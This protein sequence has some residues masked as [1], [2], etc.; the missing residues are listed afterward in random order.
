ME[1]TSRDSFSRL[2]E[3]VHKIEV[4]EHVEIGFTLAGFGSRFIAYLV[5]LL[6]MFVVVSVLFTAMV[7]A[8]IIYQKS[9]LETFFK[10]PDPSAQSLAAAFIVS[11][12]G[13]ALFIVSWFYFVIFEMLWDGASP[14][15][16]LMSIRVMRDEGSKVAFTTS[17]LRNLLR[18]ADWLP[19][20]YLAGIVVMFANKKWK[21]LGDIVAGTVVVKEEKAGWTP[22]LSIPPPAAAPAL[23]PG[24]G[25]S[26]IFTDQVLERLGEP[27]YNLCLGYLKR[28]AT[29][30]PPRAY[31]IALSVARTPMQKLGLAGVHPDMFIEAFAQ[32]WQQKKTRRQGG[33]FQKNL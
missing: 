26:S 27:Y 5:D 12:F 13:L 8:F 20:F 4:P 33:R 23:V 28:R 17:L 31:E 24:S 16:K 1:R 32:A 3:D 2:G 21:R 25:L 9:S 18:A 6:I 7:V 11:I 15:K 29:L 10:Q 22:T 30:D 14:G 19:A